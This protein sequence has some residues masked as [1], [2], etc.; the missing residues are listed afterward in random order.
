MHNLIQHPTSNMMH[1][2]PGSGS[3]KEM[4]KHRPNARHF[5]TT[6]GTTMKFLSFKEWFMKILDQYVGVNMYKDLHTQFILL[7][8][9]FVVIPQDMVRFVASVHVQEEILGATVLEVQQSKEHED[10][11]PQCCRHCH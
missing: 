9:C 4:A 7:C 5:I 10:Q 1:N 11:H 2:G 3:T 8:K 6:T